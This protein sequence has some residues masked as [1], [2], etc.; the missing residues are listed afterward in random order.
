MKKIGTNLGEA[1]TG[2]PTL[3]TLGGV[4][5]GAGR[6]ARVFRNQGLRTRASRQKRQRDFSRAS[7]CDFHIFPPRKEFSGLQCQRQDLVY[8]KTGRLH[9]QDDNPQGNASKNR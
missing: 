3:G 7:R 6:P 5:N 2:P 8:I 9:R 4:G 1:R